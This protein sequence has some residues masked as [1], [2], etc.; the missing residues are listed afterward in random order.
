MSEPI[1]YRITDLPADDRPRE[2]L[3]KLG[4]Q[5]LSSAELIAIL[6]RVGVPGES[7]VQVGQRLL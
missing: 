5:A 6:L 7:A 1:H 3:V 4:A 2:R